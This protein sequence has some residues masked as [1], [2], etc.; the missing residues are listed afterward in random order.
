[1]APVVGHL[2]RFGV[3]VPATNVVVEHDYGLMAVPGVTCH[4]GRMYLPNPVMDS[5]E[6]FLGLLTQIRASIEVAVRDVVCC[7]PTRMVMGMSAE[8]FWDGVEGNAAFTDRVRSMSG[9]LEV[10]TGATACREALQA[11]GAR[12]I[13]VFSPYQPVADDQV[14]TYFTEAGFEVVRITG[15]RCAT[16]TAIAAVTP[17]EVMGVARELDGDDVDAIVQ[18]GTNLSF[19]READ[20]LEREFDKPVLAINAATFWHALRAEGI[21]DTIDGVGRILRDH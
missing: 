14:G 18:V 9:G 12:R 5:D 10:T 7:E 19:V 3:V 1:M 16:A 15:L 20:A 6:D 21:E 8:T 4:T 11:F 2:A 13:A 17:D